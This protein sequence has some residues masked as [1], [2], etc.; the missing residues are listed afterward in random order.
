MTFASNNKISLAPWKVGQAWEYLFELKYDLGDKNHLYVKKINVT[1]IDIQTADTTVYLSVR[2]SGDLPFMLYYGYTGN[3][4]DTVVSSQVRCDC[5]G[6]SINC[7]DSSYPAG[8]RATWINLN[9]LFNKQYYASTSTGTIGISGK[10]YR[11]Q[12]FEKSITD[13][14]Q[15]AKSQLFA[16]S[17]GT[18]AMVNSYVS[19]MTPA[20]MKATLKKYYGQPITWNIL[21]GVAGSPKISVK[22]AS[23]SPNRDEAVFYDVLGRATYVRPMIADGVHY[24][25]NK[26]Q[27]AIMMPFNRRR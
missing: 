15:E 27:R 4:T 24:F 20:S 18:L 9:L 5:R 10:T 21:T 13:V 22:L 12:K 25:Y 6:D 23:G 14:Y 11:Y 16:D 26:G 7:D 19:S 17:I 1:R 3:D 8:L 2:D